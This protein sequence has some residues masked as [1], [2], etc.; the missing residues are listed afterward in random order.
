LPLE[1][2]TPL[3]GIVARLVPI[4]AHELFF[5]AA[6]HVLKTL[7]TARFVVVG[8]GERRA[9]LETLVERMGLH[10]AVTFL[11]WRRPMLGVYAD[12]DV[13]AL[14]SRNEGSPVAMIE[15]M[16]SARPVISTEVG[17]V[18]DVV[19]D[20]V[21][22][23]T[24]PSG[25]AHAMG[26]GI[27]RLLRERELADRLAAAGRRHVYPRYDSSRLVKDVR[28]LYVRELTGRRRPVPSVGVSA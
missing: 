27:L 7:P 5:E 28:D 6:A 18:P 2:Q 15:A 11:G 16:A 13:V 9:E 12:L 25:D 8:D 23:L 3:I 20:G 14:T 26:D 1:E 21:T 4:K 10:Q 24:V 17:G 22:G 19:V